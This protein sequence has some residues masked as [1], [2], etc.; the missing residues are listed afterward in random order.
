MAS[1]ILRLSGI[2]VGTSQVIALVNPAGRI[3]E[4]RLPDKPNDVEFTLADGRIA[5]FPIFV[6]D[7]IREAG[8][9]AR[10]PFE[11]T[12][13]SAHQVRVRNIGVSRDYS[14][15]LEASIAQAP[16]A[17]P[18]NTRPAAA[19]SNPKMSAAATCMMSS[20]CAAVDAV[21]E[22]QSYAARV[23]LGLTFSEESVR[24]I[25]LSIYIDSCRNGAR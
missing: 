21:I 16:A 12:R 22:T 10:V 19:Q 13:L 15:E 3:K 24:A 7:K 1:S 14:P 2:E 20:M 6:A 23:G 25:G 11:L 9:Q 8:V 5:Y 17:A 18:A 4:S